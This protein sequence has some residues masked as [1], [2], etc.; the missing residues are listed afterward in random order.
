[1]RTRDCL[2]VARGGRPVFLRA[3]R[4]PTSKPA[5]GRSRG[6]MPHSSRPRSD[7]PCRFAQKPVSAAASPQALPADDLSV[8]TPCPNPTAPWAAVLGCD[9]HI[10]RDQGPSWWEAAATGARHDRD[11][12]ARALSRTPG[13]MTLVACRRGAWRETRRAGHR[14]DASGSRPRSRSWCPPARRG[15]GAI[16]ASRA[17]IP[18]HPR[19]RTG[20]CRPPAR[21]RARRP[22]RHG[23]PP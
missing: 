6:K 10:R 15:C 21:A 19:G 9:G 16:G 17:A 8:S 2:T 5:G 23:R 7:D 22:A 3:F 12:R 20:G 1:M 18:P 11:G 13:S 14:L 4:S